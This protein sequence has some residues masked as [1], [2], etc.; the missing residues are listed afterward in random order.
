MATERLIL[1]LVLY[2]A[3]QKTKGIAKGA[4]CRGHVVITEHAALELMSVVAHGE[5]DTLSS[6]S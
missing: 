5:S 3:D 1:I 6:Q 4:R 2:P